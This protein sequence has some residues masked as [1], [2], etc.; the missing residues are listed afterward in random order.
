MMSEHLQV[1]ESADLSPCQGHKA[2]DIAVR[3]DLALVLS[4]HN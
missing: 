1:F 2:E 4:T 3:K